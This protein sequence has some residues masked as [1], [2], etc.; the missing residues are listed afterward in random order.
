APRPTAAWRTVRGRSD[1]GCRG[2]A[3]RSQRRGWSAERASR[4]RARN[5][6]QGTG[7]SASS[8]RRDRVAPAVGRARPCHASRCPASGQVPVAVVDTSVRVCLVALDALRA[9]GDV[10]VEVREDRRRVVQQDELALLGV[11]ALILERDRTD[12]GLRDLVELLVR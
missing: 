6:C 11:L 10:V 1:R 8:R 4:A 2:G 3:A 7:T 9:G 5:A 12:V